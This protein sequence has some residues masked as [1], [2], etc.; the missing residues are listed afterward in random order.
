MEWNKPLQV[1]F[2]VVFYVLTLSRS[3]VVQTIFMM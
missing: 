1:F 2:Y 3:Q